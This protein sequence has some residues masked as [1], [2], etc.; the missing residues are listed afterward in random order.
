MPQYPERHWRYS[1]GI[2]FSLILLLAGCSAG[3]PVVQS[4]GS[5][6]PDA[7]ANESTLLSEAGSEVEIISSDESAFGDIYSSFTQ[8]MA[9]TTGADVAEA[10]KLPPLKYLYTISGGNDA[11]A[12]DVPTWVTGERFIRFLQPSG[13]DFYKG[14]LYILDSAR[15]TMF[16][17]QPD[18]EK[19][20]AV[21]DLGV[22]T[23]ANVESIV[24]SEEGY[25]FVSEPMSSR[26]LKFNSQNVLVDVYKDSA[27]LVNPEK[28]HYDDR[29]GK[30]YV[31]DGVYGR[32]VV[33]SKSGKLLYALG[34]RGT[35]KGEFIQISDFVVNNKG[36]VVVTDSLSQKPMQVI[37]ND[38]LFIQEYSRRVL[39]IPGA[40]AIDSQQ[41]IYVASHS[42]DTIRIFVDGKLRWRFGGSGTEPGK[43]RV[44]TQMTVHEDK[45][46]VLDTL[47][48]RIQVFQIGD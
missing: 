22:Y 4:D 40:V 47:N 27:N 23:R 32:I 37:S 2:V 36:D 6:K 11:I 10:S 17:Y 1:L 39:D 7:L 41:R 20:I 30:L 45:L 31:S 35:A 16:R 18:G 26:V 29:Q 48:R 15:H 19:I 5:S 38:G 42:D 3:Q 43:F 25:Y 14:D 33:I 8:E 13:F 46:Y 12:S 44:V 34:K 9:I 24:F 21:L 28:L